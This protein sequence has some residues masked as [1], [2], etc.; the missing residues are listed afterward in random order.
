MYKSDRFQR[1][2]A[3]RAR[4]IYAQ[5]LAFGGAFKRSDLTGSIAP[6]RETMALRSLV[7]LNLLRQ[8]KCTRSCV[9]VYSIAT[10]F[11]AETCLEDAKNI[12]P[13]WAGVVCS[14]K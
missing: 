13:L 9:A 10:V 4:A 11:P 5:G 2:I 1:E 12:S 14:N 6:T 7:D 8:S 3:D